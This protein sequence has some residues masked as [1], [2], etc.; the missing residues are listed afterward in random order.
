VVVDAQG[1]VVDFDGDDL[2]G[3][4]ALADDLGASAEDTLRCSQAGRWSRTGAGPGDA[5]ALEAGALGSTERERDGAGP[6][7][8]RAPRGG[9]E[10]QPTRL[11]WWAGS[12]WLTVPSWFTVGG[13]PVA[14]VSATSL[15]LVR[16][17][18]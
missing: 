14:L 17:R 11:T 5:S 15:R 4:T 10:H 16:E 8:R 13:V 18:S 7:S 2:A 1:G 3:I 6:G 9:G 12:G